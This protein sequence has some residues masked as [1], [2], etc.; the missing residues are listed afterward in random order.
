MKLGTIGSVYRAQVDGAAFCANWKCQP[1]TSRR[2]ANNNGGLPSCVCVWHSDEF[3]ETP[4]SCWSTA[5]IGKPVL[6]RDL[7]SVVLVLCRCDDRLMRKAFICVPVLLCC[8]LV[9]WHV[10]YSVVGLFPLDTKEKPFHF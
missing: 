2:T 8:Q 3:I 7:A 10:H 1:R 5:V 4:P 9:A 6:V